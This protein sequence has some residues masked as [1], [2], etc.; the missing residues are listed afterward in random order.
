VKKSCRANAETAEKPPRQVSAGS[1]DPQPYKIKTTRLCYSL[2]SKNSAHFTVAYK[3]KTTAK[4]GPASETKISYKTYT[5]LRAGARK[6]Y[7]PGGAKGASS[8]EKKPFTPPFFVLFSRPRPPQ[9][10]EDRGTS[11]FLVAQRK[12]R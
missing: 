1:E 3:K 11:L 8:Q 7:C 12:G 4:D 2:L 10:L 9:E 5:F 6:R